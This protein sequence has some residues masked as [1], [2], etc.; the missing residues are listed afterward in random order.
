M[1]SGR[2]NVCT[3]FHIFVADVGEIGRYLE[4]TMKEHKYNL[5]QG[6]IEKSKLSQHQ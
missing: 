5:T 3:V 2:R 4:E 6:L 1:S